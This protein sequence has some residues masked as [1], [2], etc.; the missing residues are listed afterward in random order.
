MKIKILLFAILFPI[1]ANA[2]TV[3]DN[4]VIIANDEFQVIDS[5]MY[6]LSN[7]KSG[8]KKDLCSFSFDNTNDINKLE[9][10]NKFN[11]LRVFILDGDYIHSADNYSAYKFRMSDMSVVWETDL[12]SKWAMQLAPQLIG[13]FVIYAFDDRIF[14]LNKETGEIEHTI[15]GK[16]LEYDISIVDNKLIYSKFNGT[17]FCYDLKNKKRL[18]SKDVGETSGFGVTKDGN[19][20]I[21]PSWSARLFCVNAKTGKEVWKIKLD[22]I[23]NGCGSGFEEA[24]VIYG[25]NFYAPHRDN[26]LY[27]FNKND[28]Q[29][30]ENI[31]LD[32]ENIVGGAFLYKDIIWFASDT[33]LFGYN[34]K[35]MEMQ[36]ER[37]F[38]REYPCD[39]V[40]EGK[41][42]ILNEEFDDKSCEVLLIDLDKIIK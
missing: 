25:D 10:G 29:L 38:E 7:M 20:Y 1:F 9:L 39:P 27:I 28:G 22:E 18:W 16:D 2:Q 14:L 8:E 21:L 15:K 23:K 40:L 17:V 33:Q 4:S 31:D 30:V 42:F 35:T 12:D 5:T 19:N 11:N 37:E 13:G 32:G 41:W 36:F 26:G 6:Y 24:P 34:P 3:P